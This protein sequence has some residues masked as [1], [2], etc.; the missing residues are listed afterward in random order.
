MNFI[1]IIGIFAS[2]CNATSLL[3]QLIKILKEKRAENVSII[4][5]V[6]LF[7]GLLLWIYYGFLTDN[8]IIIISNAVSM[9]IN[10]LI[11]SFALKYRS[12]TKKAS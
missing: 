3:P 8:W 9:I 7:A 1:T 12:N 5:L 2:A 11:V 10:I 6:V 4:M